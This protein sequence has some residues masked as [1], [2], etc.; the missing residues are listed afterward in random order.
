MNNPRTP[1][2]LAAF[3]LFVSLAFVLCGCGSAQKDLP[4]D[5]P[6]KI[7]KLHNLNQEIQNK[8]RGTAP[9]TP[10]DGAKAPGS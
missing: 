1:V 5:H 4:T 10:P 2:F 9:T 3:T 7:S 8:S 6:T